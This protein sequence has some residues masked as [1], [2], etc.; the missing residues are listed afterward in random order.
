MNDISVIVVTRNRPENLKKC[1]DSLNKSSIK[2][3]VVVVDQSDEKLSIKNRNQVKKYK[4]VKYKHQSLRGKT[5]GLNLGIILAK[6]PIL[7]FTD[8][9]CIVSE[10]WIE[11]IKRRF[12]KNPQIVGL[13]GRTLPYMPQ[14][15][16]N[17][18][19]PSTFDHSKASLINKPVNHWEKIGFGNNMAFRKTFFLRYGNFKEWLGPGSIGSNAEDGEISLRALTNGEQLYFEPKAMVYHDRFL[20][21][22]EYKSQTLSYIQGEM[23]CYCYYARFGH[24]FAKRVVANDFNFIKDDVVRIKYLIKSF[25][26]HKLEEI[27]WI[28]SKIHAR[29][30]GYL[31]SLFI[32]EWEKVLMGLR[33]NRKSLS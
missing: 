9:D 12:Y 28:V 24:R 22:D 20:N 1:L 17:L 10:K 7:A 5:K 4:F 14:L 11:N 3:E 2:F 16:K 6:S 18:F 27:W 23:A 15:H 33:T 30:S 26:L 13:F 19:C 21:M 25:R 8:D 29:L 32:A 31:V